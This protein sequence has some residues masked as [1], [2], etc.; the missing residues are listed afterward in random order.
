[1]F[2]RASHGDSAGDS[3]R[4]SVTVNLFGVLA[5]HSLNDAAARDSDNDGQHCNKFSGTIRLKG[6]ESEGQ[7]DP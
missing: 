6:M 3:S 5:T 2:V 4:D 1:V 7:L